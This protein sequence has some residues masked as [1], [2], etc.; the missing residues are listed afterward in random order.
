MINAFKDKIN[1]LRK[2]LLVIQKDVLYRVVGH[3]LCFE[4]K[5]KIYLEKLFHFWEQHNIRNVLL[6]TLGKKLIVNVVDVFFS[7]RYAIIVE[8]IENLNPRRSFY[9]LF[10]KFN[11]IGLSVHLQWRMTRVYTHEFLILETC[12]LVKEQEDKLVTVLCA[13][14][15]HRELLDKTEWTALTRLRRPLVMLIYLRVVV[16]MY[17]QVII[18]L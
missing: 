7:Q 2:N 15:L 16:L 14:A 4:V 13:V 1:C 17:Q 11:G 6:L 3:N 10:E 5:L 18:L 12:V 8:S 9:E